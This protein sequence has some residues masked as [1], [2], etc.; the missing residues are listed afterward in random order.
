MLEPYTFTE[1]VIMKQDGS[2]HAM[3][4]N[5]SQEAAQYRI[6]YGAFINIVETREAYVPF[7]V[8]TFH[9]VINLADEIFWHGPLYGTEK[10]CREAMRKSLEKYPTQEHYMSAKEVL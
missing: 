3:R 10:E 5:T 7:V 6:T 2:T 8:W 1:L 9:R 4:F